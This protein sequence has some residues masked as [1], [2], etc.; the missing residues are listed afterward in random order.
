MNTGVP[1]VAVGAEIELHAERY[2]YL[3]ATVSTGGK[4][5]RFFFP[6]SDAC[7]A[8]LE[9]PGSR[10]RL[11]GVLGTVQNDAGSCNAVGIG[12]PSCAASRAPSSSTTSSVSFCNT[13]WG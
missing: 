5:Y 7:R 2:R 13:A 8:L 3:D 1:G 4:R 11:A 12:F 6:R 10:F 9:D